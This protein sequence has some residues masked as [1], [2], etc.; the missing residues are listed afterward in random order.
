[1]PNTRNV[2]DP[3]EMTLDPTLAVMPN[4]V[5]LKIGVV[6][7]VNVH[8]PLLVTMAVVVLVDQAPKSAATPVVA[9]LLSDTE[10]VQLMAALMRCG[11]PAMH[12]SVLAVVGVPYAGKFNVPPVIG[13]PPIFTEI[14]KDAVGVT[15]VVV[16]VNVQP[17]FDVESPMLEEA[18]D[19]AE[20]SDA[21]P[22]VA[23]TLLET[24]MVHNMEEYK[25]AGLL[26]VQINDDDVV[27]FPNTTQDGC[28]GARI[29]EPTAAVTTN[30]TVLTVGVVEKLNVAPPFAVARPV[31]LLV[32]E[33]EKSDAN[34]VVATKSLDTEIVQLMTRPT[35]AGFIA[36]Q[37][38]DDAFV[39]MP[40]VTNVKGDPV[41]KPDAA[42][43]SVT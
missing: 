39:G 36:A 42:S 28:P 23:A 4:A 8:P 38:R 7:N 20:K 40:N 35:R 21:T 12:D 24:V 10:I 3:L 22:V 41:T 9:P 6:E 27:G 25:R 19:K 43:R 37:T 33:T 11:V 2:G 17:P 14:T 26:T 31:T 30:A 29:F 5:L 15:G 16:N 18:V 1:M 13:T 34:P 32:A